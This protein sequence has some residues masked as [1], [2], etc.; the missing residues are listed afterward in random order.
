M[1]ARLEEIWLVLKEIWWVLQE[2]VVVIFS[3]SW[4]LPSVKMLEEEKIFLKAEKT[5]SPEEE[6]TTSLKAEEMISPEVAEEES[7]L[8]HSAE[9]VVI[10][11]PRAEVEE[12]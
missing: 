4:V 5:I 8:L 12:R 2:V 1:A 7:C 10:Q 6:E 11:I 9:A 3:S